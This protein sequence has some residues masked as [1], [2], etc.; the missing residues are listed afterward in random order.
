MI[1]S[2]ASLACA[3]AFMRLAVTG[4]GNSYAHFPLLI[5]DLASAAVLGSAMT[6]MLIGHSYLI[7]PAMS[8]VPLLRMLK[9]LGICLVVRMVLAGAG[10]WL[11][12]EQTASPFSETETVLWLAVRWVLGL[13]APLVLG[14]M[15][16]E[17]ARIRSTQSATGILYV[18]VIVSF[19][20]EMTSQ[21]LLDKTGHIL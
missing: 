21:L 11:W 9:V 12:T 18:V 17:T 8:M 15:A 16:W 6:A 1:L 20:G 3:L 10:L 7:A 19:L 2:T 14:W 4:K 5:D 13:F